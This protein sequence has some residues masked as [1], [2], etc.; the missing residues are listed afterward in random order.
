MRLEII[1]GERGLSGNLGSVMAHP[2]LR[3]E[4]EAGS[5]VIRLGQIGTLEHRIQKGCFQPNLFAEAVLVMSDSFRPQFDDP[6]AVVFDT[7]PPPDGG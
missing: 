5:S 1:P 4:H 3:D 7:R 2:I 6:C